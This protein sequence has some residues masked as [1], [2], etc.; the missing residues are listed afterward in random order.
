M[1]NSTISQ[2]TVEDNKSSPPWDPNKFEPKLLSKTTHSFST[3]SLEWSHEFGNMLNQ[4]FSK[5]I[6]RA[7]H[8]RQNCVFARKSSFSFLDLELANVHKLRPRTKH[9]AVQLHHFCQF[10]LDKK[11]LVEKFCTQHQRADMFAKA[12]PRD[13]FRHLRSTVC[14]WQTFARECHEH[15][16]HDGI[17]KFPQF[18]LRI[19]LRPSQSLSPPARWISADNFFAEAHNFSSVNL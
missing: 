8:A 11:I 15:V 7:R 17:H 3:G 19:P 5:L 9:L 18:T 12:L 4:D 6:A 13:A 10:A 1:V 16:V 2:T 14:G